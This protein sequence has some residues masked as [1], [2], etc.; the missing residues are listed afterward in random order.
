MLAKQSWRLIQNPSSLCAQVLKAKYFKDH[1][2]LNATGSHGMS[3]TWRSILKGL[4]VFKN[5]VVWRVGNGE[6]I[7]I[8]SDPWLPREWTRR[9]ITTRRGSLLTHVNDLLDPHTGH[10][11]IE[12]VKQT[13]VE[14]DVKLILSL[15]V[16]AELDDVLAWH[17]DSRG[18]FFVRS[19]YKMQREQEKREGNR[20][21]TSSSMGNNSDKEQWRKLWKLNC[22]S[23][24]KHSIW[25]FAHDSLAV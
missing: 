10:W 16:H 6:S 11:D 18:L 23:K 7:K 17:Y 22:S 12:L 15:P 9:S 2:V 13:F 3:Y 21:N 19:A 14:E 25:R 8:W 1:H 4:Q 5:G 24:I 20:G